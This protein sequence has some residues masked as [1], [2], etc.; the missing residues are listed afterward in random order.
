[1]AFGTKVQFEPIREVAFG[2]VTGS[3][4]A[5]GTALIDHARLIRIVNTLNV[6]VYI[7]INGIDNHIR[8]AAG[9]FFIMDFSANKV[10]DDG[11]FLS[12]GTVFYVKQVSGA[13]G[14]GSL[15]IEVLYA[16]GGV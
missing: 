10:R 9:S 15:W 2:S 7:S 4:T 16:S 8:M 6:E 5:V 11:M 14:S 1:M 13:A 12:I 3:Y